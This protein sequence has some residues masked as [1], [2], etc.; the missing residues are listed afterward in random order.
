MK[1]WRDR[2]YDVRHMTYDD[3]YFLWDIWL[4]YDL[5]YRMIY[6]IWWLIDI[7]YMIDVWYDMWYMIYDIGI[8]LFS[9][10]LKIGAEQILII[11]K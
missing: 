5:G 7:W 2:D 3:W 1:R 10:W 8:N 11:S 4:I 9:I 6:D